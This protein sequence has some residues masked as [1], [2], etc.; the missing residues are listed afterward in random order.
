MSENTVTPILFV[1]AVISRTALIGA[2]DRDEAVVA[3][4]VSLITSDFSRIYGTRLT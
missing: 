4:E 2:L 1:E 3:T